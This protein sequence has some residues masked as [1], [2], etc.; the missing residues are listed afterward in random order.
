MT[1]PARAE[2]LL[3]IPEVRD[4]LYELADSQRI[5]E[6]RMLADQLWRRRG[7][8]AVRAQSI[9]ITPELVAAIRDYA[10]HHPDESEHKVGQ[11]FGVNQGRVSEALFGHRA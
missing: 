6:L 2:K 11:Q 4:R 8:R 9:A 7:R 1:T 5:P 10:Y 3:T